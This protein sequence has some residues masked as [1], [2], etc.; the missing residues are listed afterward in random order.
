MRWGWGGCVV[1]GGGGG[2]GVEVG[3]VEVDGGTG[4][5]MMMMGFGRAHQIKPR[6]CLRRP[7]V[8][9]RRRA[10]GCCRRG[11]G[12]ERRSERMWMT[13]RRP[14][15]ARRRIRIGGIGG[16]GGVGEGESGK[17]V[18]VCGGMMRCGIGIEG[19]ASVSAIDYHIMYVCIGWFG[20]SRV[21]LGWGE[22]RGRERYL[23]R[24]RRRVARVGMCG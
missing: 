1:G 24:G 20:L 21:E 7:P 3:G 11:G 17:C 13:V 8:R 2:G 23:G 18:V 12:S 19:D 4:A 5:M 10:C 16:C 22:S 14:K 15:K 9:R 6:F